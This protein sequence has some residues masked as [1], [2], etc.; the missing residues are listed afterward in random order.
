MSGKPITIERQVHIEDRVFAEVKFTEDE[1]VG[2]L[3]EHFDYI[4]LTGETAEALLDESARLRAF[5]LESIDHPLNGW[6]DTAATAPIDSVLVPT[7]WLERL[8]DALRD[9]VEAT[10]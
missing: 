3:E 9:W 8:R 7:T 2:L 10:Q 1:L 6:L 5:L 4:P